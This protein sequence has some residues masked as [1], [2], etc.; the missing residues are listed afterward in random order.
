MSSLSGFRA[1]STRFSILPEICAEDHNLVRGLG[2]AD[3]RVGL[4]WREFLRAQARSMLAVDFFTVE[5]V[6]LPRLYV[7]FFIELG[8]RRVHLAGSTANPN[9]AWVTQQ[10]RQLAWSLPER[11]RPLRFLIRDRDSKYTCSFDAIFRSEGSRSSAH[12]SGRRRPTPSPS[13]SS[14]PR[15]A[16]ASTGSS[17]STANTLNGCCESSSTITTRT[18]RIE[19]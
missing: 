1:W 9:S 12:R 4:S 3:E 14:A 17:S 13:V 10:A 7:L 15:A 5:S 6:S 19:P 8:S 18:G 2:P 11:S 16:N